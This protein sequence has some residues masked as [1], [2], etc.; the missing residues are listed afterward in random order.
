MKRL[1]LL[2]L[3][4]V[5]PGGCAT[6]DTDTTSRPFSMTQPPGWKEQRTKALMFIS[7]ESPALQNFE[8]SRRG[9]RD[10]KQQF[11]HTKRRVTAGMLPQELAEVVIDEYQS[12]S[13][14]PVEAVEENAPA[15][16]AGNPAFRVRLTFN[17]S[18]G[19][20]CRTEIY[21]FIAGDWYYQITYTAPARYYFARDL[22]A[23]QEMVKSFTL[24]K[25]Q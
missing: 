1:L 13:S 2:V 15:T 8:V 23:V 16:V 12:D 14:F 20:K 5:F 19:L 21:G 24:A 10:E 18:G 7:R 9:L 22:P 3:V 25:A 6:T 11:A 4:L 17:T